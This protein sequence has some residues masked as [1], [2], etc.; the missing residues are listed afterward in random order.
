SEISFA[1]SATS[2][3][4]RFCANTRI[5]PVLSEISTR[6]LCAAWS[7]LLYAETMAASIASKRI[8]LEM[9]RS[10]SSSFK[11]P[12]SSRFIV[13][14][15]PVQVV[16]RLPLGDQ[17][18]LGDR[19]QRDRHTLAVDFQDH[20]A[21]AEAMEH[22]FPV[23]PPVQRR[24]GPDGDAAPGEP[25]EVRLLFQGPLD[26]RR[27]DLQRVTVGDGIHLVEPLAQDHAERFAVVQRD[28]ARLVDVNPEKILA[29]LF[30]VL[31]VDHLNPLLGTDFLRQPGRDL[32][33]LLPASAHL[34]PSPPVPNKRLSI[35]V[36]K[37]GTCPLSRKGQR[38]DLHRRKAG[39]HSRDSRQESLNNSGQ[40]PTGAFAFTPTVYHRSFHLTSGSAFSRL[41]PK[42]GRSGRSPAGP[43][44]S[45]AHGALR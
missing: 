32:H 22:A 16:A 7:L 18:R 25:L 38:H 9:P 43:P 8:S 29:P 35:T 41:R 34:L 36:R 21:V 26:A 28:A 24:I 40:G 2:S 1:A 37:S 31:D 14:F 33:D 12:T 44:G 20:M 17:V 39:R 42:R 11:A 30:D 13:S 4:T 10:R 6:T 15:P 3:T 5:C 45:R 23:L 19:G 27:R